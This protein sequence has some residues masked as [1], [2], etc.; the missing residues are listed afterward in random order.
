M[1]EVVYQ[2]LMH[3]MQAYISEGVGTAI[4]KKKDKRGCNKTQNRVVIRLTVLQTGSEGREREMDLIKV[5]ERVGDMR[6][7]RLPHRLNRSR[8]TPGV[9]GL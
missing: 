6:L 2:Y 7:L 1:I 3:S 5:P 4:T 9:A 8:G